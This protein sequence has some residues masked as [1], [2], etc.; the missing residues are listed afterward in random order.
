MQQ[1]ASAKISSRCG[2]S[3]GLLRAEIEDA[4]MTRVQGNGMHRFGIRAIVVFLACSLA[5]CSLLYSYRNIDRYIRWS[6]DDY[7]AWDSTQETQ[8]R[9]RLASQLE[10]HQKTQLPRYRDWLEAIDRT[11]DNDIDVTQL[12]QA[13]DQLQS[14]WQEAA[15]HLQADIGAQLAP[16]SDKQVRDLIAVIREKQADLKNE[17]DDMT[18][19]ELI[20]KRKREMT[21]T[22]KYW[23]GTLDKNQIALIDEWAQRLPDGRS[24]WL[25]NRE[26]WTDAFAQ[27]LQHRHEPELFAEEI[28]LLFVT[29]Q[30]N[31]SAEF[32]ELSQHNRESTLQLLAELHNSRT[33]QQRDVEH[34]RI[35]QWLGRL[36]ELAT[37]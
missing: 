13:A 29:P 8:L 17:Y 36:D 34:K 18:P 30:E 3:Q 37:N 22:I 4:T 24:L 25:N 26:R 32:R 19:A 23:L 2:A 20:K 31:W 1:A 14:F 9:S 16:L 11:L 5:G 6:L 33:Q 15:A 7:I 27:A 21:K 35:V 10:W 28:H 12:A